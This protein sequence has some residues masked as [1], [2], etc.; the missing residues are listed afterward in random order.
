[1]MK[2]KNCFFFTAD[3]CALVQALVFRSVYFPEVSAENSKNENIAL[4]N[5]TAKCF[6]FADLKRTVNSHS[7]RLTR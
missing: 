4:P 2:G 1:M 3:L 7:P 6:A 5:K